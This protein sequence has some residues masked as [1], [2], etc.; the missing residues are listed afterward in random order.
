M[1][2]QYFTFP[3][4]ST[5]FVGIGFRLM[6]SRSL[7]APHYTLLLRYMRDA[8]RAVVTSG[9]MGCAMKTRGS[10]RNACV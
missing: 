7:P 3:T 2:S 5:Y 9:T 10:E 1:G 8:A 4:V 6:R